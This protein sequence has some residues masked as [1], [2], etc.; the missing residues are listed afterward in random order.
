MAIKDR[1]LRVRNSIFRHVDGL[2]IGSTMAALADRGALKVLAAQDQTNLGV[3]CREL[4]GNPGFL[5]VAIRLLA[6]QGWVELSGGPDIDDV[7]IS[8][9][10]TGR[11][12]LAE[13]AT[14]YAVATRFLPTAAL[15]EDALYS[16]VDDE[17]LG[18]YA[19]LMRREWDLPPRV[20][21]RQAR[22]QVL[23]HLNGHLLAP[24]MLALTARGTLRAGGEMPLGDGALRKAAGILAWQGWLQTSGNSAWLTPEGE[25]AVSFTPQYRYPL[26]YLPL[27][28][29]VPQLLF[30][31]PGAPGSTETHLDRALDV[32]FSADVFNAMCRKP[33]LDIARPLFDRLPV[34]SQPAAVVD[35]GCGDGTVLQVLHAAVFSGTE[36]GR[37]APGRELLMVGVDPSPVARQITANRLTAAGI[38]NIVLDGDIADPERL[39]RDLAAR[40]VDAANALH[41]CKS[42]I[43]DRAYREPGS[44]HAADSFH[45]AGS[46]ADQSRA[47]MSPGGMS[48]ADQSPGD[49]SPAGWA[50]AEPPPPSSRAFALA[51]GSGVSAA[52]MALSLAELF[53]SWLPLTR[54][55][56]WLVIEAQAV[57]SATT[58]RLLG[59][60]VATALD[61]THGYSC[62]YPVE[63]E[64]FAWAARAAGFT[65]RAHSEPGA[66]VLGYTQ[67]TIDHF[68]ARLGAVLLRFL[69][70]L[71]GQRVS[72]DVAHHA[73]LAV[74]RAL[75]EPRGT[76]VNRP[77]KPRAF[78]RREQVAVRAPE[79]T[80]ADNSHLSLL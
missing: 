1:A 25:L 74:N 30:G 59:Q 3:L 31:D 45:Y 55:H 57:P 48:R 41:I 32:R 62:Q 22:Q 43:H 14:G 2:A 4:S 80:L 50:P 58:A 17:T 8:P 53:R 56:G 29:R 18:H 24:I 9:T 47:N 16:G 79:D 27:L 35:M 69:E 77:E 26:V 61:A 15:I 64:V 66:A 51:D 60:T 63:P 78:R 71:I 68:V 38:P 19:S 72:A 54:K 13:L 21:P 44:F 40:G 20:A 7:V 12:V 28:R 75:H 23:A 73:P 36:R 52:K 10:A 33:F 6:C 37:G 42:A 70:L 34:A 46:A 67:L 76:E 11:A 5:H 39:S 49:M 65:S